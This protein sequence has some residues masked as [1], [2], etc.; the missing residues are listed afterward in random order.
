MVFNNAV[1]TVP[2][3]PG[4]AISMNGSATATSTEQATLAIANANGPVATG[5]F[6]ELNAATGIVITMNYTD[7]SGGVWIGLTPL[8]T[9]TVTIT[10]LTPT[11]IVG[12]FQG[13]IKDIAMTNSKAITNGIFDL[14]R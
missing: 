3:P 7:P 11:R 10:S 4:E 6:T 5:T 12:T 9:F 13:T 14:S 2:N 1:L 8:N